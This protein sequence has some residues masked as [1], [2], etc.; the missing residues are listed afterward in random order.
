MHARVPVV[1]QFARMLVVCLV[2][3]SAARQPL[4]P[5]VALLPHFPQQSGSLGLRGR[6]HG[7]SAPELTLF[8]ALEGCCRA[9]AMQPVLACFCVGSASSTVKIHT[10]FYYISGARLPDFL[11]PGASHPCWS[12]AG[13]AVCT[14]P[15]RRMRRSMAISNPGG[16]RAWAGE[17]LT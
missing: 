13:A 12:I 5:L 14:T 7:I 15:Q 17:H 8:N 9:Q 6:R 4:Q 16:R 3:V 1:Q 10:F 2:F 11:G